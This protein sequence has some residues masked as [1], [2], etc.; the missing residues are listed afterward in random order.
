MYEDAP[1]QAII[2]KVDTI[3][4]LDGEPVIRARYVAEYLRA[5]SELF[6]HGGHSEE[7]VSALMQRES[8]ALS[9]ASMGVML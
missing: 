2:T 1:T 8:D 9:I 5:L 3:R 4:V 6:S 7:V